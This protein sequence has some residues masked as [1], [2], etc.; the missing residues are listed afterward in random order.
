[1]LFLSTGAP[2]SPVRTGHALFTVHCLMPWPRQPTVG[3]CSSRPLDPIVARLSGAHRTVRCYSPRAPSCRP[4]CAD[5]P[6]AHWV[7]R[8]TLDKYC[9]LSGVPLVRWLT[10]HFMDFFVVFLGFFFLESWTSMYLLCL[11]LRCCILSALVQIL[12]ASCEL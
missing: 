8:C 3:I 10:I 5:C 7:L 2:D 1:L 11:L 12:F 4:L 9:S 6:V